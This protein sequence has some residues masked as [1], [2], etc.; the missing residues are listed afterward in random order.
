MRL[1]LRQSCAGDALDLATAAD[2]L[3]VLG[4]AYGMAILLA[5]PVG[6]LSALKPYSLFDQL[7]TTFAL[8]MGMLVVWAASASAR[9][10]LEE[11]RHLLR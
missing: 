8:V 4:S 7:A 3:F 5:L 2:T 6:I 9:G 1:F 11:R 10:P